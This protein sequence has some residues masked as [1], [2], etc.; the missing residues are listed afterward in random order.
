MLYYFTS[1]SYTYIST[2]R[3][4]DRATPSE[5]HLYE[6]PD[7]AGLS[8]RSISV[9]TGRLPSVSETEILKLFQALQ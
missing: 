2:V 9:P 5:K 8:T 7:G 3:A 1:Y 4:E 6:N